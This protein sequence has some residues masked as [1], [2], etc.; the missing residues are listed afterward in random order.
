[1]RN[2]QNF[3]FPQMNI[4]SA[5]FNW[6]AILKHFT[7]YAVAFES[8][9][10]FKFR[11]FCATTRSKSI[12]RVR[13][14]HPDHFQYLTVFKCVD[15]LKWHLHLSFTSMCFSTTRF[16]RWLMQIL[17]AELKNTEYYYAI[18]CLKKDV[19]LEDDDV[20][21]TLVERKVLA[22]GTKHPYLCHLFCTFQTEVRVV[23]F[24]ISFCTFN[25]DVSQWLMQ[26]IYFNCFFLLFLSTMRWIR[27]KCFR[28]ISF[29]SWNI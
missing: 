9:N 14:W 8:R 15:L 18:K 25:S 23:L 2:E 10:T 20:E 29:L 1:M 27:A 7:K 21:C 11:I 22:L 17:L 3:S 13:V 16:R 19:V 4:K 26:F 28:V 12:A 6:I 24:F 5:N